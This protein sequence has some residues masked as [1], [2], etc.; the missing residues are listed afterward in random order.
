MLISVMKLLN[1]QTCF[2]PPQTCYFRFGLDFLLHID[3]KLVN[4][5]ERR[6]KTKQTSKKQSKAKQNKTKQQQHN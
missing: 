2:D 1:K 4:W 3:N 5:K 6:T